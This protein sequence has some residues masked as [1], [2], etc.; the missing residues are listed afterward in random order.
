M[1]RRQVRGAL[2]AACGVL[3]GVTTAAHAVVQ[4]DQS[5]SSS[6]I[7]EV[8]VGARAGPRMWKVTQDG[9]DH[10][11]WILGTVTPLPKRFTW[12]S[13]EV[14]AVLKES[15]EVVPGLPS[16]AVGWNPFTLIRLYFEWRHIQR[17][18]DHETLAQTLPP[19]L[20][21]RFEALKARYA[22]HD[23]GIEKVRPMIAAE[24]LLEES[25]DASGLTYRNEVQQSVLRLA[26]RDGVRIH[27]D[28]VRVEQ[29][30]DVLK[31][32]S[33]AP[34]EGEI[35]CLRSVISRLETDIGPMQERA[36][37]WALGDVDTIRKLPYPDSRTICIAALSTSDRVKNLIERTYDDW[38]V[39][40]QDSLS[41]NRSTLAVQTMDRLLGS[42][43]ALAEL[44]SRGYKVEGP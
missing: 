14:E 26:R 17:S 10:V 30:V 38:I 33:E 44:R 36:R 35:A 8:V 13:D 23:S 43:G 28:K 4:D 6:A 2:I 34:R 19:A 24:R 29:P 5:A 3:L 40:V 20:Y 7:P 41:R 1:P 18:P 42:H 37:A 15:Q 16:V 25:L 11:L 12:Q 27:Q 31:D 39:S 22:P 9:S 21:A 32:M